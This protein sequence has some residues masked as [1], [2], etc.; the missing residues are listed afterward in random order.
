VKTECAAWVVSVIVIAD[1]VATRKDGGA[2]SLW[3]ALSTTTM[4]A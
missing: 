4:R 1:G 2:L 3:R